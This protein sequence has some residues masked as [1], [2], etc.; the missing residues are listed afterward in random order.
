MV[1]TVEEEK[2]Q[3]G[4]ISRLVEIEYLDHSLPAEDQVLWELEAT[5]SVLEPRTPPKVAETSPMALREF[6][7]VLRAARWTALVPYKPIKAGIRPVV[8]PLMG[9]MPCQRV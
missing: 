6:D 7:A 2:D 9:A 1:R 8:A 4:L 3:Y 5:A